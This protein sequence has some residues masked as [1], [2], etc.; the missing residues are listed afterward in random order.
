MAFFT[1]NSEKISTGQG[2]ERGTLPFSKFLRLIILHLCFCIVN[3]LSARLLLT[4]IKLPAH[5]SLR[6]SSLLSN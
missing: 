5:A 3:S 1:V 6:L 2:R 4:Y